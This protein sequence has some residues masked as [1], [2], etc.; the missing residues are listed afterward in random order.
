MSDIADDAQAEID[1]LE[2]RAMLLRKPVLRA[3]G[4]CW[5]C[6][7]PV[8]SGALFCDKDCAADWE[9]MDKAR[10]RNHGVME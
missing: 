4:V 1:I 7:E 9:E 6:G 8:N 5:Y 3:V 2:K 10:I